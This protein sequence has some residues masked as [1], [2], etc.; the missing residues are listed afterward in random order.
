MAEMVLYNKGIP[1]THQKVI[2]GNLFS[3]KLNRKLMLFYLCNNEFFWAR[4]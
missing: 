2:S 3:S 1:P 4:K